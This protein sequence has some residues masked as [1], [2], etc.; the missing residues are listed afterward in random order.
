M[1]RLY[2]IIWEPPA[3]REFDRLSEEVQEC[4]YLALERLAVYGVGDVRR[5][6]GTRGQEYRL[7]VGEYRV[8]FAIPRGTEILL[9]L[10][11][12]ARGGAY[13]R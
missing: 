4:I 3:A 1:R 9:V 11:V 13:K 2:Q 8:R 5:I 6:R 10:H 7:R 12:G